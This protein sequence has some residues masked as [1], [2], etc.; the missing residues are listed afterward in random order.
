MLVVVVRRGPLPGGTASSRPLEREGE[1]LV[2]AEVDARRS[3]AREQDRE[4]R[5]KPS[6]SKKG[7]GPL[8]RPR[9]GA[10]RRVCA[11]TV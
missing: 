3:P 6:D 7:I 8:P 4:E 5:G 1:I 2:G 10:P 9:T 11:V